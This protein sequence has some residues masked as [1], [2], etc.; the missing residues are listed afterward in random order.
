[1]K[2]IRLKNYIEDIDALTPYNISGDARLILNVEGI[3][4]RTE[5]SSSKKIYPIE[6]KGVYLYG[7]GDLKVV[8]GDYEFVPINFGVFQKE[9]LAELFNRFFSRTSFFTPDTYFETIN[10]DR[11]AFYTDNSQQFD[12]VKK[13]LKVMFGVIVKMSAFNE[14]CYKG[15]LSLDEE[16]ERN[17][18]G[19]VYNYLFPKG[20][21]KA[22]LNENRFQ[23]QSLT[24]AQKP[25]K[26]FLLKSL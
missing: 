6:A 20:L 3:I 1:M 21:E 17:T 2:T 23:T 14:R 8:A 12:L 25:S 18:P 7:D 11:P 16:M 24:T 10:V 26:L 4:Y 13:Y 9:G 5:N 19:S 22:H 15:E